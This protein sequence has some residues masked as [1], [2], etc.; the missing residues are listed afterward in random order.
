MEEQ[1]LVFAQFADFAGIVTIFL[2]EQ[3]LEREMLMSRGQ[4]RAGHL[5]N[6]RRDRQ[7]YLSLAMTASLA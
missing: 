4:S 1:V 6:M 5:E 3:Y 2:S 7:E